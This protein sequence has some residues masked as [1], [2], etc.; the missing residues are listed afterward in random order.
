MI[1]GLAWVQ[2]VF[3]YVFGSGKKRIFGL[4]YPLPSAEPTR[5]KEPGYAPRCAVF[6]S[7]KHSYQNAS[8]SV[9]SNTLCPQA[10]RILASDNIVIG[11]E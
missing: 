5:A 6:E 7:V 11:N 2:L 4:E 1:E 10:T 8:W 9:R 3:Y